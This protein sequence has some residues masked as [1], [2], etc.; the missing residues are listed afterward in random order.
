MLAP[1]NDLP[2]EIIS[3]IGRYVL[4]DDAI[5][6]RA[7]VPLT[8]VC[9]YW[10]DSI[11][12]TPENWTLV[13]NERLEDLA[14][15]SLERS[16]AAPL[17]IRLNLYK[18]ELTKHPRFREL[19][20]SHIQD[21]RSLFV[22]GFHAIK[23]LTRALPNFP[24][25]MSNLRSLTLLNNGIAEWTQPIDPFYF[26][27]HTLK[28]LSLRNVPLYPSFLSIRTLT[29]LTLVVNYN[30]HLDTL[31]NFLE[32]SHLLESAYLE[33]G[34]AKP[35]L[36]DSRHQIPIRNQ[37]RRLSICCFEAVDGRALISNIALRRGATLEI[38]YHSAEDEGL[39]DLLSGVSTAHLP[40]LASPI[41]I[42]YRS[43]QQIIRLS[44][45][46]GRFTLRG[47]FRL[48][49]VFREFPP[50]AFDNIREFRLENRAPPIPT[51]I[52]LSSF[53]SLEVLVIIGCTNVSQ[54]LFTLLPNP[55]HCPLLKTLAFLDCVTT[56]GSMDELT[57]FASDREGTTSTPLHRVVVVGSD[58]VPPDVASMVQLRRH[59]PVVEV[60]E[61]CKLPTDLSEYLLF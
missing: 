55:T 21:T 3:H 9:R 26:S 36:H 33:I 14:A 28:N 27:T 16:K 49:N 30:L 38:D 60:I 10:R 57:R 13:S 11:V 42:E 45:P 6:T 52:H 34:F 43:S 4:G 15:L 29:E 20:L 51:E 31:L 59:V 17:T 8:H 54:V 53:P 39:A 37:L 40:N 47:S 22:F 24:K 19:L 7:I 18:L 5:D 1:A 12:S 25:S 50:L 46:D 41:S 32:E 2:P 58:G 48:K 44:G 56:E 61:G 23:E 35:S